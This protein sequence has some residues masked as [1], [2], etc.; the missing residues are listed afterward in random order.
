MRRRFG[1]GVISSVRILL[2]VLGAAEDAPEELGTA[3]NGGG[4]RNCADPIS[5]VTPSP[6][7]ACVLISVSTRC[8]RASRSAMG[9]VP[10]TPLRKNSALWAVDFARTRVLNN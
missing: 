10:L 8:S 4:V 9:C 2:A 3:G 5:S 1:G 6:S 7:T